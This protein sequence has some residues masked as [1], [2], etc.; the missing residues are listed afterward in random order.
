MYDI[1]LSNYRNMMNNEIVCCTTTEA[2]RIVSPPHQIH[3]PQPPPIHASPTPLSARSG[4][5]VIW[6]WV[7]VILNRS[8]EEKKTPFDSD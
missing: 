3:S 2:F 1:L 4:A 8:R 7:P 6:L 5:A